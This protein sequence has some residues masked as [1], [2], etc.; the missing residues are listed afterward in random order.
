M[1]LVHRSIL[2]QRLQLMYRVPA[3]TQKKKNTSDSIIIIF[4]VHFCTK[5][6]TY[7][8]KFACRLNVF[9]VILSNVGFWTRPTPFPCHDSQNFTPGPM[10]YVTTQS[11]PK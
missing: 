3:I 9:Q 4:A 7:F 10:V 6:L 8:A 2:Q 5:C 11:L 1:L